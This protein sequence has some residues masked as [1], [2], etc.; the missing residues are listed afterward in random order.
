M[1]SSETD[2]DSPVKCGQVICFSLEMTTVKSH[3][4]G[5][6]VTLLLNDF[7]HGVCSSLFFSVLHSGTDDLHWPVHNV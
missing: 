6:F 1:V 4:F 2:S 3:D 5:K 7:K